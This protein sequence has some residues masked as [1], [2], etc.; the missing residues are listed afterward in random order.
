MKEKDC[1]IISDYFMPCCYCYQSNRVYEISQLHFM[2]LESNAFPTKV[3]F[4]LNHRFSANQE[5]YYFYVILFSNL[6]QHRFPQ[7]R[8][9]GFTWKGHPE[10]AYETCLNPCISS[11][12]EESLP[13]LGTSGTG[14]RGSRWLLIHQWRWVQHEYVEMLGKYLPFFNNY[15][16]FQTSRIPSHRWY[17]PWS[18]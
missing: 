18:R 14:C 8:D 12:P 2:K 7:N 3:T 5:T 11:E 6:V 13:W 16:S 15:C 1:L 17:F 9:E 10:P 4:E